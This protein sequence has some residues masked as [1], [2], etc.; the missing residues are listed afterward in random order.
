LL[1][2]RSQILYIQTS[3]VTTAVLLLMQAANVRRRC[4]PLSSRYWS[5][6]STGWGHRCTDTSQSY[7]S[8]RTRLCAPVCLSACLPVCLSGCT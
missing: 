5:V 1:L 6:R 4:I 3:L 7:P 2:C 8:V